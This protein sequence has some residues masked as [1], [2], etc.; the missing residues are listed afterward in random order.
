M[1]SSA[2]PEL[3]LSS[4]PGALHRQP[5]EEVLVVGIAGR[6]GN[7][8]PHALVYVL[9]LD[10]PEPRLADLAIAATM[11]AAASGVGRLVIVAWSD[12]ADELDSLARRIAATLTVLATEAGLHVLDA[13]AVYRGRWHS[14]ECDD[15]ACCPPGGKPL[16][17]PE[18]P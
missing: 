11:D 7:G 6:E 4:L 17:T 9:R 5:A 18:E 2:A 14:Y 12:T 13:L 16:P 10:Q 3:L 15:P 8:G 1:I